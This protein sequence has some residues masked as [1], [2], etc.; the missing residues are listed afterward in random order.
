MSELTTVRVPRSLIET[1]TK[2]PRAIRY[3][4]SVSTDVAE[5]L[6]NLV[7]ESQMS[8]D[9]AKVLA[10]VADSKAMAALN[11]ALSEV[12]QTANALSAELTELRKLIPSDNFGTISALS[13]E[14]TE[15]KRTGMR[16]KSTRNV[17][18]AMGPGITSGTY[19]INPALT[20]PGVLI[21]NG[22]VL[23]SGTA[24]D[25]GAA[26]VVLTNS[27]TVTAQRGVGTGSATIYAQLLEY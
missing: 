15:L 1:I 27:T 9:Q 14:L 20:G 4:E 21:Y 3:L 12:Q 6:P 23:G 26:S 7:N 19:T 5:V 2:D 8:A 10:D 25:G 11:A 16:P 24:A 17:T 18:I 13:A 22:T